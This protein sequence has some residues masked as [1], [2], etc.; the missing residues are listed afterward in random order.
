MLLR[1][2]T[3]GFAL[4]LS[5]C[6][7]GS[8]TGLIKYY[9][10]R[11]ATATTTNVLRLEILGD[12]KP[13][14]SLSGTGF[15]ADVPLDTVLDVREAIAL[16]ADQFGEVTLTITL[17]QENGKAY[18]QDKI[19]WKSSP[20]VPPE[21]EPYFSEDASA[22]A[23]VYLVLPSTRGSNVREVWVEGDL[24]A[25]LS[26]GQYYDIPGDDQVLIQLSEGDG[27]KNL[28]VKYRNIFGTDGPVMETQIARKSQPPTECSASPVALTT[29]TGYV[30]I[31]I[32]AVNDGPLAFR[33][34]GDV[35]TV[36]EYR[37]FEEATVEALMLSPGEGTKSLTVKIRDAAGNF[38]EDI[39]LTISYDRSYVP[40]SV[41]FQ[42]QA[43]WTDEPDVVILPQFDYLP[44]DNVSMFISGN[45]VAS[46]STFQ[47]V[48][49]SDSVNVTLTPT[50]GTRHVIVQY[51]K[52]ET[53][54]AEVTASIF[55]KP[56]VSINGS[57]ATVS[58]IPSNIIGAQSLTL[59]GCVEPYVEVPY[60]TSYSCTKAATE[61]IITYHLTDG[62]TVTRSAAF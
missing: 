17:Y 3:L 20:E 62:S 37:S 41:A 61:A 16:T 7:S 21:P 42:N 28:K 48:P 51:R 18:L 13:K 26:A 25:S 24:E 54:M 15:V 34:E 5:A 52:D 53:L 14:F 49:Y 60:A 23:W 59:T 31:R 10:E 12:F 2:F 32:Q 40:G 43:L 50:N 38:C 27:I 19:V 39:P 44:G 46:E 55:L 4:V 1:L 35:E 6:G 9:L 57:G 45:V 29:A 22:D 47:W 36:K 58:V 11:E 56:Y 33:V 8:N 30:R